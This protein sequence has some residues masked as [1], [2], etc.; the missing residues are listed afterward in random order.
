MVA[1]QGGALSLNF[2][3]LHECFDDLPT[4]FTVIELVCDDEGK[5]IDWIFRY[6]NA[7]LVRLFRVPPERLLNRLFYREVFSKINSKKWLDFYY[8]VAFQ[9]ET[10]VLHEYSPEL[11]KYL[12]IK[13]CPWKEKGFC[14]LLLSEETRER[15]LQYRLDHL[16]HLAHY[17]A[18]TN[19]QN[20]NSYESFCAYFAEHH[21]GQVQDS[22][23]AKS[24]QLWDLSAMLMPIKGASLELPCVGGAIIGVL[25]VDI[26]ELKRINDSFGHESGDFLIRMVSDKLKDVLNGY[27]FQ[28]FRVGGDEFVVIMPAI[29]QDELATLEQRLKDKLVNDAVPHFPMVL[30]AV[31]S[32]WEVC[33]HSIEALVAQADAKMYEHKRSLKACRE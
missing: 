4:A 2:A 30:A 23:D 7:E 20:R 25:F 22:S 9:G 26:N 13:S 32:A 8:R 28:L 3:A 21:G 18:A 11:A 29:A 6:V 12:I 24:C 31:G 14:A 10:L 5:P 27:N 15:Q 17:D 16:V 1:S 19:V 33:A